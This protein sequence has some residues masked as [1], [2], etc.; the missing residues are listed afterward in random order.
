MTIYSNPQEFSIYKELIPSLQKQ[1]NLYTDF[2]IQG[3]EKNRAYERKEFR[4][5]LA[6]IID[7]RIFQQLMDLARNAEQYEPFVILEGFGGGQFIQH[8]FKENPDR[9]LGVYSTETDFLQFGV[10][11]VWTIDARGTARFL[12]RED[13]RLGSPKEK[14]E[15][16]ER[17]GMKRTWTLAEKKLYLFEAFGLETGKALINTF[18]NRIWK[19]GSIEKEKAI[20][21]IADA[22]LESGRR[23]GVKSEEIYNVLFC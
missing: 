2:V 13:V 11:L 22:T 18:G 8:Y 9:E 15:F 21:M 4:D 19:L 1:D 23:I 17:A 16:P 14:R 7:R 20:I 12:A 5:F 6:S 3:L 10:G